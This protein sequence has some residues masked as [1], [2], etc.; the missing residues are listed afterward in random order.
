[1]NETMVYA[2]GFEKT[3]ATAEEMLAFLGRRLQSSQWIRKPTRSLRLVPLE[4]EADNLENGDAEMEEILKDTEKHTRLVLKVRGEAYPV[5]NCAIQTI[6]GRAGI[7]G[8]GL[9]KL[10]VRTYAKVVNCCLKVAK[11]ESLI[12]IADGKVSA[13][14][15]GDAH[16]YSVL[17]MKAIFETTSE[18]LHKNFKGS[19]YLEGSGTYDHSVMSA[20]WTLAGNQELLDTYRDALE[21]Y[22]ISKEFLT[23]ALRLTTSDVAASGVN[24]YPMLLTDGNSHTLSLGSPITLAHRNH[25]TILDYRNNLKEVYARYQD[26]TERLAALL[27]IEI[28]NPVNCLRLL[29]KKL[30]I[31]A[32]IRNEVVEMYVAQNG[33]QTCTA[34]D[35]YYAMNEAPF[36]AACQG[37]TGSQLL[38]M[39]ENL[40]RALAMDWK[41][42]DV[43]GAVKC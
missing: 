9:R 39:E 7:S 5:R 31:K 25:S 21:R 37:V 22:G 3:F 36:Y 18:Y 32:A 2:D 35:L 8:E 24:L 10:D 17:D 27:E 15:G 30:K 29:M 43:Y 19:T 40:T 13:V 33:E 16:D 12:K 1:M 23:P 38:R 26:A 11:G 20:M 34:H 42:F 6:L 14:H 41:E 4:K 28:H